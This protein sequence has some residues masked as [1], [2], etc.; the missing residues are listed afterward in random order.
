MKKIFALLCLII[1]MTGCSFTKDLDNT[2]KKKVEIFLNN[3]QS[4]NEDVLADLNSTV[5]SDSTL[6]TEQ[7]EKYRNIIKSNYQKMMYSIKDVKEDGDEAIVTAEIE[8]VDYSDILNDVNVYL[9]DNRDTF[10]TNGVF[11]DVK[12]NDYRIDEL[13]KADNMVKYTIAFSLSKVDDKWLLDQ[14]D[15]DVLDK[16]NG[17][18][19]KK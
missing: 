10:M 14:V 12:F 4:L 13:K 19:E 16:I 3:Y 11:D 6:T 2:P 8:V 5:D 17:M 18:Y 15:G 7:K 9:N 1:F